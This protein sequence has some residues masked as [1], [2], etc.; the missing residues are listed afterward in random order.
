M[1]TRSF[2]AAVNSN[3]QIYRG[4]LRNSSSVC[5]DCDAGSLESIWKVITEIRFQLEELKFK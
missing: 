2:S 4:V 3:S 5:N 1:S